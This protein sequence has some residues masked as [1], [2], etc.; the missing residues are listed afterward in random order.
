MPG[1][2]RRFGMR[3]RGMRV[4]HDGRCP[5]AS[6]GRTQDTGERDGWHTGQQSPGHPAGPA[7][8][9]HAHADERVLLDGCSYVAQHAYSSLSRPLW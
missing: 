6:P 2:A 4:R 3:W 5:A 9:F 1:M 7:M 8:P